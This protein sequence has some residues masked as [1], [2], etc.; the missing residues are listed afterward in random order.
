[1]LKVQIVLFGRFDEMDALAPFEVLKTEISLGANLQAELVT[2]D[3]QNRRG[4]GPWMVWQSL[5]A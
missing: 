3:R 5:E 4:R 2:C 1:M